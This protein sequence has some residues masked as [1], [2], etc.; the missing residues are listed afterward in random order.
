MKDAA[1]ERVRL[2]FTRHG[3]VI[4]T[5][6]AKRKRLC[7]A[8]GSGSSR[9][10]RRT[11][12]RSPTCARAAG[13]R[14]SPACAA[15]ARRARTRSTPT[16]A[17]AHRLEAVRVHA[18]PAQLGRAAARAGRRALRVGR[19]PR[20]RPAAVRARPGAAA[21]SRRPTRRTCRAAIPTSRRK[22]GFEWAAPFRLHRIQRRAAPAT[23]LYRGG[24][25]PPAERPSLAP[26]PRESSHCW[27]GLESR[28]RRTARADPGP[29]LVLG[30]R[31]RAGVGR[32][33]AVR[34]LVTR[35]ELPTAR[36]ARGAAATQRGGRRASGRAT[37]RACVL[38]LLE[39][40]DGRLGADPRRHARPR[41]CSRASPRAIDRTEGA[42]RP[43]AG[44]R[45]AW[46]RLHVAE[47]RRTRSPPVVDAR[48]AAAARRRPGAASA[49]AA[50]RSA[51]RATH[52]RPAGGRRGD[53]RLLQ[54]APA[55]RSAR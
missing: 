38:E 16:K 49:A 26:R 25:A 20:P 13:T 5:D 45:W 33:R 37:R 51:T 53:A 21:G 6:E 42:A 14:S 32:R 46:G 3:P 15:G 2:R 12:P 18:R 40:P 34:G 44:R 29:L 24:L 10:R 1:P 8:L 50:R 36:A 35:I 28:H 23:V 41:R 19:V 47:L 31:A 39:H 55:P 27:R 30:P 11:S 43:R 17:G 52:G 4:A 54:V 9:A 7:R 48:L 22:I